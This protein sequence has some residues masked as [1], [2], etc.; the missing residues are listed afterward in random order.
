MKIQRKVTRKTQYNIRVVSPFV[1]KAGGVDYDLLMS[2]FKRNGCVATVSSFVDK[3]SA[4]SFKAFGVMVN[5]LPAKN[6]ILNGSRVR[7][8]GVAPRSE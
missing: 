5:D 6:E 3:I 2:R 7:D 1:E 4:Q 8:V